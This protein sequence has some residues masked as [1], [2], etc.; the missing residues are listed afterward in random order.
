MT[1]C[2]VRLSAENRGDPTGWIDKS[3]MNLFPRCEQSERNPTKEDETPQGYACKSGATL[4]HTLDTKE[5]VKKAS[6]QD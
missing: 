2:V 5:Q 6:Q 1:V 3:L 4:T